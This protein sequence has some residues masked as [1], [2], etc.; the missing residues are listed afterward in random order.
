MKRMF[1]LMVCITVIVNISFADIVV[2]GP[3]GQPYILPTGAV[4]VFTGDL[5]QGPPE[6]GFGSISKLCNQS[7]NDCVTVKVPLTNPT[8]IAEC[9]CL[10][11]TEAYKGIFLHD[12][13]NPVGYSNVCVGSTGPTVTINPKLWFRLTSITETFN[14]FQSFNAATN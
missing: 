2:Y 9:N 1:L 12:P 4:I 6:E 5:A 13:V 7:A 8:K 3:D 11:D 14:N 10:P